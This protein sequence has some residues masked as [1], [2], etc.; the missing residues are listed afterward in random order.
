MGHQQY[1]GRGHK[2]DHM[3]PSGGIANHQEQGIHR[4]RAQEPKT[5]MVRKGDTLR[6][7][8]KHFYGAEFRWEELLHANRDQIKDPEN[9]FPGQELKIPE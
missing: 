4:A 6:S 1:H 9:L 7:I 3:N 2:H 5:Y 8:A